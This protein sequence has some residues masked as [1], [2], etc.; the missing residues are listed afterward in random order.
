MSTD[1]WRSVEWAPRKIRELELDV[2]NLNERLDSD[3]KVREQTTENWERR[4]DELKNNVLDDDGFSRV[5]ILERNMAEMGRRLAALEGYPRED[6]GFKGEQMAFERKWPRRTRKYQRDLDDEVDGIPDVHGRGVQ[7]ELQR[8]APEKGRWLPTVPTDGTIENVS[9][10]QWV[11]EALGAASMCWVPKP[12]TQVFDGTRAQWIADSLNA[13]IQAV[14]DAVIAGTAK[15]VSEPPVKRGCRL[16]PPEAEWDTDAEFIAHLRSHIDEL[17]QVNKQAQNQI[18]VRRTA[19][20]LAERR[21]RDYMAG[22]FS[23]G[24]IAGVVRAVKGLPQP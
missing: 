10:D 22:H 23:E 5:R 16:C 13:H 11:G 24:T 12:S 9:L 18:S 19:L 2:K 14:I 4:L 8:V 7:A 15:A 20:E 21:V 6:S 1:D 3:R 17:E